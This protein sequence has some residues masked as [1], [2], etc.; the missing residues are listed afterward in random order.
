MDGG[1]VVINLIEYLIQ[2]TFTSVTIIL[3]NIYLIELLL[4]SIPMNDYIEDIIEVKEICLQ[5]LT[6]KP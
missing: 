5:L 2:Y 6:P 3:I 4:I 1:Y